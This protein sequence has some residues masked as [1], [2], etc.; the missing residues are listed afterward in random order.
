[1]R[2]WSRLASLLLILVIVLAGSSTQAQEPL[3]NYTITLEQGDFTTTIRPLQGTQNIVDYYN[4]TNFQADTG[5]EV[6]D[7]S[8]L[9]FY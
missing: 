4:Y 3:T 5:L 1:M 2:G 6:I 7:R 8:M 9:F